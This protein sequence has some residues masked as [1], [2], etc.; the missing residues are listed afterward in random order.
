MP[1][2]TCITTT[3]NEG[4]ALHTSVRSILGQSFGDFEYII[5][6]DGSSEETK[7]ILD[8]LD[9]PRLLVIKQANDGLSS[10]RNKALEQATGDYICF[11]DADDCRPNWAFAAIADLIDRAEPDLILCPGVLREL[12]G[13][14]SGFYDAKVFDAIAHLRPDGIAAR[15]D[16]DFSRICTLAQQIEPQSANKVVRRE[17]LKKARIGFPNTHFFEDI[18]FHTNVIAA[19]DRIGFLDCPAFTYFRRYQRPQITATATDM[20]FDIIAV[21]KLTLETF[22]R[23]TEFHDAVYRASVLISCLKILQWCETSISHHHRFAFRQC[24]R[25][26][27]KL[28]NPLYLHLPPQIPAEAGDLPKTRSYIHA[29]TG[30]T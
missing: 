28:I 6:D 14:V 27:L 19:A 8:T 13:E 21:A 3:Y 23:R 2:L 22:S 24:A 26:M 17:F 18:F 12:R 25:V 16:G 10:A 29:L 1:K 20:R 30:A 15:A 11:L 4:R 5:V 9:D 7:A